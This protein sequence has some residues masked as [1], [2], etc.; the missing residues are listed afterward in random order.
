MRGDSIN[1]ATVAEKVFTKM[2]LKVK[3]R[4][5]EDIAERGNRDSKG[6]DGKGGSSNAM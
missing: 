1:H 6:S 3:N 2:A 5:I 4:L